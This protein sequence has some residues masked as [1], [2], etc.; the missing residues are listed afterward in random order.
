MSSPAFPSTRDQLPREVISCLVGHTVCEIERKLI[1]H[2][3]AYHNGGRTRAA[4]VLGLSIR[5]L[6]NKIHE[7]EDRGIAVPTPGGVDSK[8]EC[9]VRDAVGK[10]QQ[11]TSNNSQRH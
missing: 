6:R 9:R 8:K 4:S 5:T 7:Y 3:L 10:S 1:L 11:P 2:T